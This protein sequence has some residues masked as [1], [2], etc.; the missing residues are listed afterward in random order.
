M[1]RLLASSFGL[2]DAAIELEPSTPPA[3]KSEA[4]ADALL[5][6]VYERMPAIGV[7]RLDFTL[8]PADD[9]DPV[10]GRAYP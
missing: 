2:D 10:L 8:L 6:E 4:N 7:T 9:E 3:S 1:G 5:T